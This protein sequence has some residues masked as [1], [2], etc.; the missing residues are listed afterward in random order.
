MKILGTSTLEG[1]KGIVKDLDRLSDLLCRVIDIADFV[2]ATHSNRAFQVAASQAHSLMFEYMNMLNTTTGL[3][4]QLKRAMHNPEVTASWLEEEIKVAQILKK[5]FSQS[6]ID[7]PASK[8]QRFIELSNTINELGS[9]FVDS[10]QPSTLSL[11]LANDQLKGLSPLELRRYTLRGGGVVI[12]TVGRILPYILRYGQDDKTREEVYTASRTAASHAIQTLEDFVRARAEL[13]QLA[14]FESFAKMTLTDKMAR[15]PEAVIKFL[16]ALYKNNL[17]KMQSEV[18]AMTELKRQTHGSNTSLKAWDRDFY[19][20][21]SSEMLSKPTRNPDFISSF[22]SLGTVMQGLSRIFTHLYG[23][24]LEPAEPLPGE[25]WNSDVRRLD[26]IDEDQG[27]I[28]VLYCDL[29]AREGK[30]PNPAH[31]TLRCSRLIPAS[32]IAESA[33]TAESVGLDA[34]NFSLVA[35]D[36][37]AT[38]NIHPSGSVNQLPTIALIC[39]FQTPQ[40]ENKPA[41]LTPSQV[42][43]LFH[44]MGHAVHSIM[45]RTTFQNVSGTRCATDFAELPS[46]LM[47]NFATDPAVLSLYARHWETDAPLTDSLA[48]SLQVTEDGSDRPH[49]TEWQLQLAFLDQALHSNSPLQ[50]DFNSDNILH[51]IY[52]SYGSVPEPRSTRW[53]G[54]FG[55]LVGYGGLYYSYLFDRA[56]AGR[57][58]EVVFNSGKNQGALDRD[59]GER[60][61]NEV[62]RWGGSR[63][64]WRLVSG[65]LKDGKLESGGEKAMEEVGRWGVKGSEG[66]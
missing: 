28:A 40:N 21:R 4:D 57:V 5:D 62:L 9:Q 61:K 47:E 26:V 8:R 45:G 43:T 22:F 31:F 46:I 51:S 42:S 11:K 64:P 30:S 49:D 2:R 32:E 54:F 7:L 41:L 1:Y 35:N 16:E 48:K 33:E 59:S 13:A 6:A 15:T 66:E 18:A 38:S 34:S 39:D 27:R 53:Q 58:W 25:T 19:R 50:H 24:R 52:D 12:P 44:E 65:L 56:I 20:A 17:P 29:F 36:G 37:M 10:M 63:D 55:H 60:F 3:N 14:G 23:I